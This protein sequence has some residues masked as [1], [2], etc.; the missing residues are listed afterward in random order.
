MY[1][2][3][4]YT[5]TSVC[6]A[7]GQDNEC[8]LHVEHNQTTIHQY[9][10]LQ[11]KHLAFQR[12]K[13]RSFLQRPIFAGSESVTK[14]HVDHLAYEK[15]PEIGRQSPFKKPRCLM[16]LAFHSQDTV[17]CLGTRQERAESSQY[18]PTL[19]IICA[20]YANVY[21]LY[22]YIWINAYTYVILCWW[23]SWFQNSDT[24]PEYISG[25][26]RWGPVVQPQC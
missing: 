26:P 4:I 22:I 13:G 14:S 10:Q 20:L 5:C 12:S 6:V 11:S 16:Q 21:V 1:T 7:T 17:V 19:N 18:T 3:Y 25:N 9:S 8:K 23:C 2:V 24:E 15:M